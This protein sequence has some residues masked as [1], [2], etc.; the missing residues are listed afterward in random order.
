MQVYMYELFK[1]LYRYKICV[2]CIF[3]TTL[4][5]VVQLKPI[6]IKVVHIYR[7]SRKVGKSTSLAVNQFDIY[8]LDTPGYRWNTTTADES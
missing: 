6:D 1:N 8:T 3:F 7:T 4:G 2:F 5:I